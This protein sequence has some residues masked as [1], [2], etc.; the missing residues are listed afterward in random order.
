MLPSAFYPIANANPGDLPEY[1]LK[2]DPKRNIITLERR[3][4]NNQSL[5]VAGKRLPEVT[6]AASTCPTED[7]GEEP[8]G[9]LPE[10]PPDEPVGV[11]AGWFGEVAVPPGTGVE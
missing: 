4:K 3:A 9:E 6:A 8:P 5:P 10:L 7:W 1:S 11:V 2:N